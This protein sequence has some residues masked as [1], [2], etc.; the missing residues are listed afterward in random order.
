MIIKLT[1]K[2]LEKLFHI[3]DYNFKNIDLATQ[4]FIHSSYFAHLSV[5]KTFDTHY[6]WFEFLG[7]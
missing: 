6:E 4:A 3:A 2:E 7:D 1:N 5:E